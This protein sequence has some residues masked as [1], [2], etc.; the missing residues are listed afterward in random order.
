VSSPGRRILLGSLALTL[1][2]VGVLVPRPHRGLTGSR[3]QRSSG[4]SP[5]AVIAVPFDGMLLVYGRHSLTRDQVR[6][7]GTALKRPVVAVH[8]G[9]VALASGR[10]DFPII[11]VLS[12][13]ADPRSYAAAA[14]APELARSLA[15]GVVLSRTGSSLRHAGVGD[16]VRLANGRKLPVSAVVGDQLLGGYEMASSTAVLGAPAATVASYVLVPRGS[17]PTATAAKLRK[18]LPE[19]D[20]RIQSSTQN[21]YMSSADTVLTQAQI[22]KTFGEFALGHDP[23]SR[24]EVDSRWEARWITTTTVPQLGR[25]TCNRGVI[26]ALRAAMTE[27]TRRGLGAAVHTADFQRQGGCWSPRL[28]RFGAGQLSAHTWGIA[29]DINV[30]DNPLG[31]RPV[32]DARLVEIMARHGFSWGGNWLRPDG[33][34]FQWRGSSFR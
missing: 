29:V 15:S 25:I 5:H 32:Q 22:K 7:L 11:P 9:E 21:G 23:G 4:T 27:V 31:V 16:H 20:L 6:A 34:H 12:F 17:D 10:R 14:H 8:G 33:A 19:L 18:A 24:I 28:V 2:A 13:T 1:A 26:N 30:D 3:P